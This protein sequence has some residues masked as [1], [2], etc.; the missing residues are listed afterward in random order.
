MLLAIDNKQVDV[1]NMTQQE[2]SLQNVR[3]IQWERNEKREKDGEGWR[4]DVT[5]QGESDCG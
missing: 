3:Q 2:S 5:K 1:Q 4:D